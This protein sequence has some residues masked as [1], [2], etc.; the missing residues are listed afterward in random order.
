MN[1][2]LWLT[3]VAVAVLMFIWGGVVFAVLMKNYFAKEFGH[4]FRPPE[5]F[6]MGGQVLEN[7]IQ[8]VLL[9]V[10][11][12]HFAHPFDS[13]LVNGLF[14]GALVGALMQGSWVLSMWVNFR[15][16]LPPVLV[17]GAFGYGRMLAVG[18]LI[19][20]MAGGA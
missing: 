2:M 5:D 4:V 18:A 16:R 1:W 19:G 14:F 20:V 8:G 17:N 3:P 7:L 15:V 13:A 6:K 10:I 11:Y 12:R 9:T